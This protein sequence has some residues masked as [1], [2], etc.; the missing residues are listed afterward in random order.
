MAAL[1]NDAPYEDMEDYQWI[2]CDT[3]SNEFGQQVPEDLVATGVTLGDSGIVTLDGA[4][5]FIKRVLTSKKAEEILRLDK[6]RGDCRI[7][8]DYRDGQNKRF[9]SFNVCPQMCHQSA[10]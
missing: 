2:V 6:S 3:T 7:I 5:T 9:L 4:D 10:G 1:F 8:G